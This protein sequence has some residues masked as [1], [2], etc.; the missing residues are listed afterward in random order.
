MDH[1]P[2]VYGK[3]DLKWAKGNHFA[4]A[5]V[6]Y[7]GWKY[8]EEYSRGGSDNPEEATADGTPSWWTLNLAY[9]K[10][11]NQLLRAQVSI[12]NLLDVHYKTYASGISAPGRNFI[13][14]LSAAF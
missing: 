3:S 6:L 10:Q 8:L 11:I 14:S 12:E 5:Y 9:S 1:I 13:L 4:Q 2:P 7:H